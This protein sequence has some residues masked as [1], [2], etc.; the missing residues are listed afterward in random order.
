MQLVIREAGI[1]DAEPVS[2]LLAELAYPSTDEA[3]RR[4]IL[5]FSD[6]PASRLVLAESDG[7]VV[8]LIATHIV[9]RLD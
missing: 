3:T 2:V 6:D 1:E 7:K 9:P 4:H 5:R 8:G